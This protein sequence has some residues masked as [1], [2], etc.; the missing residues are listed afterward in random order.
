MR[1]ER[2]A[3]RADR[4][5]QDRARESERR[6]LRHRHER[7]LPA[8][9]AVPREP[10]AGGGKI[11]AKRHRRQECEREQQRCCFAADDAQPAP[12]G[13]AGGLRLAQLL[14]RRDQIEARRHRLELGART[15]DAGGEVV[16]LPQPRPP[17]FERNDPRVAAVEASRAGAPASVLDALGEEER[18]RGGPVIARGAS[19]RRD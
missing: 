7:E 18:G 14:D 19:E 1:D 15:R 6:R 8:A 2:P 3:E 11:G 13:P 12:C 17:G 5:S 9:R 4:K 10:T 16:H